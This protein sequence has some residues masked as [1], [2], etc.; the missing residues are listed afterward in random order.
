MQIIGLY[1]PQKI[2]PHIDKLDNSL[3][4][5]ENLLDHSIK[6]CKSILNGLI[7]EQRGNVPAGCYGMTSRITTL[8]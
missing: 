4:S 3:C 5:R 7:K 2:L 8:D 6:I 1:L